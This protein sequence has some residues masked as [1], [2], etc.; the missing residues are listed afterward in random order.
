MI[1]PRRERRRRFV[2]HS[3]GGPWT[4]LSSRGQ[5]RPLT[6]LVQFILPQ[7]RRSILARTSYPE[8][9]LSSLAR[10]TRAGRFSTKQLSQRRRQVSREVSGA[11]CYAGSEQHKQ[12]LRCNSNF[13]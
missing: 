12:T 3:A 7:A 8:C 1:C 9:R 5:R 13:I 2:Q 10:N 11:T 4:R 6:S